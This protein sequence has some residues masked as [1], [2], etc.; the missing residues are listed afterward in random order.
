MDRSST[1]VTLEARIS[2]K[3]IL[4]DVNTCAAHILVIVVIFVCIDRMNYVQSVAS[5]ISH[6]LYEHVVFNVDVR[7]SI[8]LIVGNGCISLE[9]WCKN[10]YGAPHSANVFLEAI[11]LDDDR[12]LIGVN[13]NRADR[14][15]VESKL[16]VVEALLRISHFLNKIV[17]CVRLQ[18]ACLEIQLA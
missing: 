10:V 3:V 6:V 17:C 1:I 15:I 2:L 12:P 5:E 14:L 8:G 4:G 7:L 11:V 13:H 18:I 16:C 9:V